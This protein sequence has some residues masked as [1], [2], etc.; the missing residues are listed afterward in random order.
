M[1][2]RWGVTIKSTVEEIRERFDKDVERFSNLDTGQA[3]MVD[4]PLMMELIAEA[5][6]VVTPGAKEVLDIGCGAGNYSLKLLERLPGMNVSLLDLSRPMLDRAAVR[7]GGATAGCIVTV[8]ADVSDAE[9]G[10]ARYDVVIAAA[11]LHHLRTDEQ[12][13]GVFEKVYR[14]L[15]PGGSFW[16]SDLIEQSHA[17]VQAMTV[18]RYGDYLVSLRDAAYRD[19]VFAYIEKEDTPRPLMYQLELMRRVGF[20]DVDILHKHGCG[21]AFGGVR[22]R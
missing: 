2:R 22:G 5:A 12:W 9:L 10:E 8:R 3:A 6:S 14:C 16:V 21:A 15:R 13:E 4:A 1:E 11:V 20:V 18:R 17:G 19:E 7:V